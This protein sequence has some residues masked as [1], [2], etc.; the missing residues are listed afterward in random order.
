ELA[1]TVGRL[2]V[3][4]SLVEDLAVVILTVLLPGLGGAGAAGYSQVAWT[5][6]KALLMMIPIVLVGWKLV[7][8]LLRRV[9]RT[10]D[11]EIS[12]LLALTICMVVAAL[13]EAVGLSLALGAFLAG[14]LMGNSEY[15]HK[16]VKQTFSLRD[17]F[18]A[19]FFVTVGM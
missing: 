17:V 2:V 10:C 3:T 12:L 14:I 19:V 6:G 13:T 9:E 15:A 8:R 1:S 18:V 4:M 5:I 16:L 11:E 7:P